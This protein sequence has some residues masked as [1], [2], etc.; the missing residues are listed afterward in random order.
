MGSVVVA[1][2]L[3][4]SVGCGI[5][6]DQGSNR[7]S[8]IGRQVPSLLLLSVSLGNLQ[9]WC[10]RKAGWGVGGFIFGKWRKLKSRLLA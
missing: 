9:M 3:G 8:R 2:G 6:P 7:V 1:H 5:F 10:E 4:C